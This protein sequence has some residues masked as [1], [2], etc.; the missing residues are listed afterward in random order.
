MEKKIKASDKPLT[1][2]IVYGV[3]IAI[4]CITAIV[5]GIVA[6]ANKKDELPDTPPV[7]DSGDSGNATPNPDG[8]PSEDEKNEQVTLSF[9]S[10]V[11]GTVGT[12]HSEDLPV[13]SETLDE[14][15]LH[16]GI[17]ILTDEDAPVFAA[18]DGVVSAVYKDAL[19]GNTVEI[20]H[21]KGYK[22]V[23]SNLKDES[24]VIIKVGDEVAAGDRIGTVGDSAISEIASEAHLHF[25]MKLDGESVNPSEH[26]S[27][28]AKVS[29]GIS[30]AA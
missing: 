16:T 5:V 9:A 23:Y 29:L 12:A 11:T 22:T 3:V 17:D 30:E 24:T 27:D 20:T 1:A 18:E 15:R 8:K 13:F 25:E 19:L 4:L 6:A 10:P 28:E 14:W 2:R 21:A 7:T 26:L